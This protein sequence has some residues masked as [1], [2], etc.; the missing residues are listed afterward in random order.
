M[1]PSKIGG[2]VNGAIKQVKGIIGHRRHGP[3]CYL[4]RSA[5][6][7][8]ASCESLGHIVT[9]NDA[10]MVVALRCAFDDCL[11]MWIVHCA[12]NI[13]QATRLQVAMY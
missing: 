1:A 4:E 5:R 3:A 2:Y 11:S 8:R 6:I 10:I 9:A 13:S 7:V 12:C